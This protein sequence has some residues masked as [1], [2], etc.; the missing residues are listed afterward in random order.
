MSKGKSPWS[1]TRP[2][3]VGLIALA[4]LVGGFGSW[5]GMTQISGAIIARGRIEVDRNRQVVQHPDGGVVEEILVE[6][7]DRVEAGDTLIR[8]D[9]TLLRSRLATAET[10][11]YEIMARRGRLEAERDDRAGIA[12]DAELRKAAA[13]DPGVRELM[14]GQE[15]LHR[16]RALSTERAVEQLRGRRQQIS[17]QIEGIEAQREALN[18]QL[19]LIR[20]E[21]ANQQSLL[22]RGLTQASRVLSLRREEARL[23]GRVGELIASGAEAADKINEIELEMERLGST[24]REEAITQLRDLQFREFE[25]A[26][27]VASLRERLSRMNI[28]APVGGLVYDLS[29]HAERSVVRPADPLLYIVPQDRPLIIASQVDPIHVDQVHVGQQVAIRFS[30]LDSRTTPELYGEVTQISADAFT[31]ERRGLSFYRAELRINEGELD[32]LPE[33]VVLIPGMPVEAFLRTEDRTPIAYLVKPLT[34]YFNKAFR[35]S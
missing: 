15:R 23:R 33:N 34:D 14:E 16:A 21:L 9:P 28:T 3:L 18:A 1:A 31:D 27:K 26:Q 12:F 7:G 19:D 11:L 25:Y 35:E 10:Q 24:R 17:R 20:E 5:A 22:D 8:L 4:A 2:V 30:A 6:N 32:K 29:V 13:A